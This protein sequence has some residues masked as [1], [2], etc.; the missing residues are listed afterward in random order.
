MTSGSG[1]GAGRVLEQTTPS[2][3]AGGRLARRPR[4]APRM[5]L[6]LQPPVA[7]VAGF[8]D[9]DALALTRALLRGGFRVLRTPE[10]TGRDAPQLVLV[11]ADAS[12]EVTAAVRELAV[13]HVGRS[14]W[15]GVVG[16]PAGPGTDPDP[17]PGAD[18]W[19]DVRMLLLRTGSAAQQDAA[20][21]GL[22]AVVGVLLARV[23]AGDPAGGLPGSRGPGTG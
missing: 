15:A 4:G 6:D 5:D 14:I 18:S 1:T 21:G 3:G 12:P 20:A 10:G 16:S 9:D 23:V 17:D 13:R 8:G 19:V 11:P 22:T 7:L 2:A